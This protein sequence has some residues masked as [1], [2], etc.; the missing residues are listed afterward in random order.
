MLRGI[1]HRRSLTLTR[2]LLVAAVVAMLAVGLASVWYRLA[3]GSD[4]TRAEYV[5]SSLSRDG[6]GVARLPGTDTVLAAGD[7]VRAVSGVGIERWLLRDQRPATAAGDVLNYQ[8]RR[9]GRVQQVRVTL[10]PYP[11][12]AVLFDS[13]GT[14]LFC[15]ALL[16]VAVYVFVRRP[17]ATGVAPL[18]VMGAAL[19]GSTIP[20]LLGYQALDLVRGSGFWLWVVGAFVVYSIFWSSALHMVL[21][22]PR[23]LRG[24]TRATVAAV[25]AAPLLLLAGLVLA[26]A[27]SS[28]SLLDALG[29]AT[30][31]QLLTTLALGVAVVAG[32]LVQY[33]TA[34]GTE[35]RQQVAWVAWGGGTAVALGAAGWSIPQLLTGSSLLPWNAVGIAALPLPFSIAVAVLRHRLFDIDVVVNRTLVYGALT[36]SV[37]LV[38]VVAAAGLGRILPSGGS[39][40]ATLLATGLAALVALPVRDWLQ[41]AVNR[42]MYGDRDDPYRAITRL[43]E[44]LSASLTTDE[45]LPT[46]VATVASAL[47][48]P[49]AA[50]ELR[51][52]EVTS[53][54]AATG[55]PAGL[56]LTRLPL[57]DAGEQVGELI[58]AP[59]ARGEDFSAA[60]RRLLAG[61]AHEAGRA[62][63]SV[64]LMAELERSRRQLV[65]A[66]EEERRRLRRDLHDGLGPAIA[67][68]RLKAEAARGLT[69]GPSDAGDLLQDLDTDLARLL[70][71]VRRI[72][73]GLRPPVLDELGLLPA[74]REQARNLARGGELEL[75]V[76][77]PEALPALP[78][79]V[80]AAAYWIA[81]EALTNVRRHSGAT[82]CAV[83]VRLGEALELEVEDDGRGIAPGTPSGVGL[84]GMRERAAEVGGSCE[85]G[86]AP[87]PPGTRI[88]ARLPLPA[89]AAP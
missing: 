46:V 83:R 7:G 60:D 37:M 67:G 47:R 8:V 39:F 21:V 85:V 58:V 3:Q 69:A 10:A 73:R 51:S 29:V 41:R 23:R 52:G 84:V 45:I 12:A 31:A 72:A 66:R 78:A 15:L 35:L 77:G 16:A 59:R 43:G 17:D 28:G 89:G 57:V 81:L 6:L 32:I 70:E 2:A 24:A 34:P 76:E 20:W 4:G 50:I 63:R 27:A 33:R 62:A 38:Y 48:L 5:T 25:Y 74:L 87:N 19:N 75:R 79:A 88:L 55:D 49:Y 40:P 36:A 22:F 9:D 1:M 82:H 13:W 80:E 54:A 30:T 44:R 64:R 18:L 11:L 56:Q 53:I 71:E 26:A 14:L 68:A 65:A 42:L 86:A 61:L